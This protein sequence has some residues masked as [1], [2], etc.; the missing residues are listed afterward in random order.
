MKICLTLAGICAG[1]AGY[2]AWHD[3]WFTPS[4]VGTLAL[5]WLAAAAF[6][7]AEPIEDTED[8]Y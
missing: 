6:F 2:N 7:A 3:D 5:F 4:A 8:L 1:I